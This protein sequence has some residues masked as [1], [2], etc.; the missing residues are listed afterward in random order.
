MAELS[1]KTLAALA[2]SQAQDELLCKAVLRAVENGATEDEWRQ[3]MRDTRAM[4][5]AQFF[6]MVDQFEGHVAQDPDAQRVRK[7]SQ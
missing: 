4:L 3:V 5:S 1:N 6:Q 2:V 7:L